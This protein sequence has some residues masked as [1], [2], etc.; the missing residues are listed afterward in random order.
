MHHRCLPA[1][2]TFSGMRVSSISP[3]ALAT[4]ALVFRNAT[5]KSADV[6]EMC[7]ELFM[8]SRFHSGSSDKDI[9]MFPKMI[10]WNGDGDDHLPLNPEK[11]Q[12]PGIIE[13]DSSEI[14][15]EIHSMISQRYPCIRG[16]HSLKR[17][18]SLPLQ[19]NGF[20]RWFISFWGK[21]GL[22]SGANL[23]LVSGRVELIFTEEDFD[24]H[25][26]MLHAHLEDHP[27]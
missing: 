14:H 7:M 3:K 19:I 6:T 5:I 13:F 16:T 4:C 23:L 11:K 26:S 27:S 17:T 9:D 25:G 12:L 22:F 21:F 2:W 18:A 15:W 8:S 20:F 1:R 10:G 24:T